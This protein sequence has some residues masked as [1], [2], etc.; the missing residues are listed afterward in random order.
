MSGHG[1]SGTYFRPHAAVVVRVADEVG[2]A[3][4]TSR[5]MNQLEQYLAAKGLYA[6][7]EAFNPAVSCY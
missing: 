7:A 4:P 6:E 2:I 1:Q 5:L 3:S